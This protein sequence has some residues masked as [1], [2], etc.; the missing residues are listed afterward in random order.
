MTSRH[1]CGGER[2]LA[3]R[4]GVLLFFP[5][6]KWELLRPKRNSLASDSLRLVPVGNGSACSFR[7]SL[8]KF[9]FDLHLS[10]TAM[11]NSIDNIKNLYII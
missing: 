10:S 4:F 6:G 5:Q 2:N 3:I 7:M 11:I 1:L 9:I 8:S